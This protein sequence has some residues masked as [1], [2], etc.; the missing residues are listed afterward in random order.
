MTAMHMPRP[1]PRRA[2]LVVP[3]PQPAVEYPAGHFMALA[4]AP[5]K[6]SPE[7][8]PPRFESQYQ[9]T[10]EVE[11]SEISRI[12]REKQV[13][14]GNTGTIVGMTDKADEMIRLR[15]TAQRAVR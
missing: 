2:R 9:R 3:V 10:R 14:L 5:S 8:W 11:Q 4:R 1:A 15:M 12:N 7:G 6:V 13:A